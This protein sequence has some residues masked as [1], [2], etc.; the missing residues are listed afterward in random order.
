MG[1][2]DDLKNQAEAK[3]AGESQ[4][5][6]SQEDLEQ[7]YQDNIHPKMLQMYTY[8][9]ELVEHLNYVDTE[10]T[11]SYPIRA[12]GT[13]QD[14]LQKDY[15]VTI[16]ST[17]TVRNLKLN[18]VCSLKEPLIFESENLEKIER[19]T[20]LLHNYHVEFDR[21]DDKGVNYELLGAKFKVIGPIPVAV[22]LQGDIDTSSINLLLNNFEKPGLSKHIFKDHEITEEF[23]DDIGKYILRQ[24]SD[25]LK[26]DIGEEEKEKIR[27]SVQANIRQ[28]QEELEE[29]ERLIKEQEEKEAAE[30]KTPWKN[31]FKK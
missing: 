10:T 4:E 25:F 17:K 13:M 7:Y 14:F 11:A 16:D 29:A 15:K 9:K 20:D 26:L 1:I 23:I 21:T 3:K 28:R 18:F 2:L 12:D 6:K 8:F 5:L 22:T 31:M 30:K 27:E 19:Y 24:N